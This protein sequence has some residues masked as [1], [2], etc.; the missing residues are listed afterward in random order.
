MTVATQ[1][2][3][4]RLED[5]AHALPLGIVE[6]VVR[7]VAVTPVPG[8]PAPVLGVVNVQG[9]VI[10]V[11]G[12]R[13]LL[14]GAAREVVLGDQFIIVRR[15]D[16]LVA[17]VVDEVVGVLDGTVGDEVAAGGILPQPGAVAGVVRHPDGMLIL[18]DVDRLLAGHGELLPDPNGRALA[19][20]VP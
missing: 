3:V 15:A 10:P 7:A 16:R 9:R 20:A 14:G 13:S 17:L 2:V 12:V 4:F 18:H 1:Y 6:R 5:Q 19:G 11:V 8:A